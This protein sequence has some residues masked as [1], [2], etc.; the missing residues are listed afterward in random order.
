MPSLLSVHGPIILYSLRM[1]SF[2][3]RS[4]VRSKSGSKIQKCVSH[5]AVH[6]REDKGAPLLPHKSVSRRHRALE[7]V[8]NAD[9]VEPYEPGMLLQERPPVIFS[10]DKL[11]SSG[12]E[13]DDLY[14]DDGDHGNLYG[15][16]HTATLASTPSRGSN[17]GVQKKRDLRT[18]LQEQQTLLR[19][20]ITK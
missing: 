19:T 14:L 5:G 13:F 20:I 1:S 3:G 4:G 12:D 10:E 15:D 9:T 2:Y 8:Y 11:L 7:D 16:D 6:R 17:T 18:L